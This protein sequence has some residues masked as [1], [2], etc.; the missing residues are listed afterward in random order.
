M[1]KADDVIDLDDLAPQPAIIKYGEEEIEVPPPKT[2]A[3]LKLGTLAQKM[4]GATELSEEELDKAVDALTAQIWA[5]IPALNEKPLNLS[6]L[7]KLVA[8]FTKMSMPEE[9]KALSEQGI[10]VDSSKKAP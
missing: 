10:T 9:F 2:G 3:L 5:M 4:Q 8:M 1:S 7:Q 6:Q